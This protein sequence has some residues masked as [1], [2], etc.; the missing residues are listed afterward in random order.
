MAHK[1]IFN[2][3]IPDDLAA[4]ISYYEDISPAVANRF[5]TAVDRRLDEIAK[6][7]ESFPGDVTP[8]RF[9]K[10]D[11]FPYLIFFVLK[12]DLVSVIAILHGSTEP[13]MWRKR[14]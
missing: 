6:R 10:I 7:P 9:A 4:A 14:T 11:Q 2:A 1:L 5:R 13:G 3:S 12:S 8:I